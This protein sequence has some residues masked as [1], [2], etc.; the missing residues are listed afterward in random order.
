[1]SGTVRAEIN[2]EIK[3]LSYSINQTDP[4]QIYRTLCSAMAEYT[5]VSMVHGAV[6]ITD[7]ILGCKA[8]PM[9]VKG[10]KPQKVHS[11]TINHNVMRLEIT[12]R[13][14]KF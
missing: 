4:P 8:S 2:K 7:Y 9:N 13:R 11:L 14:K 12:Y 5:L 3:G 1:M 6:C 10:L